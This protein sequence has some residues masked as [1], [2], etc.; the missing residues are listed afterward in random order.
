MIEILEISVTDEIMISGELLTLL[1]VS[2][3][4]VS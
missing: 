4:V 1:T 2:S 3:A